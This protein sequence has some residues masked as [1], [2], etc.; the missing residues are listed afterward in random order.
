[1]KS[2]PNQFITV[3]DPTRYLAACLADDRVL[4]QTSEGLFDCKVLEVMVV[5]ADQYRVTL[6]PIGAPL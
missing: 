3:T 6:K 4:H 5:T 2:M 1:M